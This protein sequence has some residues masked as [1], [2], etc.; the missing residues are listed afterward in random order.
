MIGSSL[1]GSVEG[2]CV[3]KFFNTNTAECSTGRGDVSSQDRCL[4]LRQELELPFGTVLP[5]HEHP[6]GEC[7]PGEWWEAEGKD[8]LPEFRNRLQ[9]CV[10]KT[11]LQRAQ[12]GAFLYGI[13]SMFNI[14]V[15]E[16]RRKIPRAFPWLPAFLIYIRIQKILF[17]AFAGFKTLHKWRLVGASLGVRHTGIEGTQMCWYPRVLLLQNRN[18]VHLT[19]INNVSSKLPFLSRSP[20]PF[21]FLC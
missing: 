8:L 16:G 3:W 9:R 11:Q 1:V 13:L 14:V 18:T 5:D 17:R 7:V 2:I 19:L 4:C 10:L 20:H 21:S 6:D 15:T 12:R